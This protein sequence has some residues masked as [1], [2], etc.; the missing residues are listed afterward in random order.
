MF[1]LIFLSIIASTT[2]LFI[3]GNQNE[4][5]ETYLNFNGIV[6]VRLNKDLKLCGKALKEVFS[7]VCEESGSKKGSA[8]MVKK[9]SKFDSKKSLL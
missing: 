8:F 2:S 4:E 3:N 6:K 7:V 5:N 1:Q 9:F